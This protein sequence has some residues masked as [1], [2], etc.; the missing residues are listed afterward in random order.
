[1]TESPAKGSSAIFEISERLTLFNLSARSDEDAIRKLADLFVRHGVVR[2]TYLDAVLEREKVMPT[3]L[4]TKIGGVALPHT[5]SEHV[6]RSAIAIARLASPV[7]FKNM[8]NPAEWVDVEIVFLLA[9][10][11]KE[12][13]NPFL[14]KMAELLQNESAFQ[15]LLD[16]DTGDAFITYFASM[17]DVK[18]QA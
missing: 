14:G 16:S 7:K 8:A 11:Q 2:E 15:Q 6:K 13:V 10:A 9:I 17:I 18:D 3:G 5:D 1:M 4:A 12:Q